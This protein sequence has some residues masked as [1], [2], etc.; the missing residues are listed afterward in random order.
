MDR[1]GPFPRSRRARNVPVI[2]WVLDPA[3]GGQIRHAT[4]ANSRFLFLSRFS[5]KYFQRYALPGSLTGYVTSTG[6]SRHSRV[7]RLTRADFLA[8][9][10]NCLIPLNL[11]RVGGTLEDALVRR[12]SLEPKLVEA[13]DDAIERAYF[14]LDLDLP[15]ETHLVAALADAGASLANDRFNFCLQIIEEVVQD[16]APT[17]DFK[18]ARDFPVLIQSDETATPF[19]AGGRAAFETNVDM[20]TT[21]SRMRDA[22]RSQCQSRQRRDPQS[23]AQR[24]QC[25]LREHHRGKCHPSSVVQALRKCAV[26][27]IPRRQSAAMPGPRLHRPVARIRNRRRGLQDA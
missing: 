11:R 14:D 8:R 22:R 1:F 12:D 13:V 10:H 9:P 18:I 2:H 7:S 20:K 3:P 5:E 19:A 25:R 27:P 16:Q 6:V 17:V 23:H 15:I 4:T 26:L 24:P 21:I